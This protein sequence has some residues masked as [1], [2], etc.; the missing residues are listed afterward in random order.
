MSVRGV[1]SVVR[2]IGGQHA[3]TVMPL[4]TIGAAAKANDVCSFTCTC[5]GI[6]VKGDIMVHSGNV[7]VWSGIELTPKSES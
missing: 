1:R 5:E 2:S 3:A 7:H 4:P 6:D